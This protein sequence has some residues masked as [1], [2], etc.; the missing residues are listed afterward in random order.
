MGRM[1]IIIAL[2]ALA[3]A[4]FAAAQGGRFR[5]DAVA[6]R[7]INR[8]T[9]QDLARRF[10]AQPQPGPPIRFI[11]RPGG[12]ANWRRPVPIRMS[13]EA[14]AMV[15]IAAAFKKIALG[16][17]VGYSV[18]VIGPNGASASVSDGA[19]RRSPNDAPRSMSEKERI[20]IASV[21]KTITAA[22]LV[23]VVAWKEKSLEDK[24][25][26]YLPSDWT[27]SP[28]FK[29]VTLRQLLN[30]T[31]RV[32][33]ATAD[34]PPIPL[35]GIDL[36]GLKACVAKPLNAPGARYAN[37]NYALI[38]LIL[39]KLYGL[40]ATT[41]EEY[42]SQYVTIVNRQ[43]FNS[44]GLPFETCKSPQT[45][46][47]L[48]YKSV[49]DNGDTKVF[50]A[51]NF[52]WTEVKK[53]QNWGDMTAICGSQGWNLNSRELATFM[54]SLML[55]DRIL[56]QKPLVNQMRTD[57]LGLF[58]SNFGGGLEAYSHGGWHPAGWNMGEVNTL[59]ITFNNDITFGA[60]VNSRYNGN[61]T[62]DLITAMSSAL[63]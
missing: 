12:G 17:A 2:P 15:K 45:N 23:K 20:S 43:T 31:S 29:T 51:G 24:A 62:G 21:S 59:I 27:F 13:Q 44:A 26:L 48:S 36:A 1:A 9:A 58:W 41:A 61:L 8:L 7:P 54:R 60:I 16:K 19:A 3:A 47:A 35:C 56:P 32:W 63:P 40:P 5:P 14:I 57:G 6:E 55:T 50:F 11:P 38:R 53:G 42:G 37:A 18:T 30:H 49:T 25:Y 10:P 33:D 28:S 46:P 52:D 34:D 4:G 39:V 22:T